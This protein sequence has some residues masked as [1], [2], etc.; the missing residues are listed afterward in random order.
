MASGKVEL[1]WTNKDLRLLSHGV[2][3]YEWVNLNDWRVTEVR[4]LRLVETVGDKGSGNLLIEGDA[5]HTLDAILKIPELAKKYKGKVKLCYIDPPFNTGQAFENYNDAVENSVWLT[6]L[7][8]RLSQIKDLLAPDGSVWL[9]LDDAQAHRARSVLDE[10]FG[11]DNFVATIAWQKADSPRMDAKQFSFSQDYIH[12]YSKNPGWAPNRA[13]Q[14]LAPESEFPY[15]EVDGRRYK[16]SPLRK[17]GKNSARADRPNLWYPITDPDGNE[18]WP[19]KPDG[20][21]GNWRWKKS[22]VEADAHLLHWID[23]GSG[24]QPYTKEYFGQ[25]KRDVPPV[26]WWDNEFADHNR[27]AKAHGK[28]L[29]GKQGAFE[30]PKPERLIQHILRIGSNPGDLVLDCYAGSGTTAAVAHKM[31]RKWITSELLSE[32][33]NKYVMPRLTLVV[34]GEDLGGITIETESVSSSD[35]PEGLTSDE[36]KTASKTLR[37]LS[38]A[39][40]IESTIFDDEESFENLLKE[41]NALAKKTKLEKKIW[42]GGGGF[43]YLRVDPSM[44]VE[45]DGILG[46]AEWATGGALAI[47]IAAQLGYEYKPLGSFIGTKGRTRLA[48]LDGMLTVGIVDFLVAQLNDDETVLIVAQ[49]LEPGIDSY[50]RNSRPGSRCKKI[51]RDLA[52]AS[53]FSKKV[54]KIK[55]KGSDV[56]VLQT[57]D[58]ELG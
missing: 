40:L 58:P 48:V 38:S 7:R 42:E 26:T 54:V 32:T 56:L 25:A 6:M 31:G 28:Q 49:T 55:A 44:F 22:K 5:A 33:I 36:V 52:K 16:S 1:T 24:M 14:K 18:C 29:F 20:T 35:L 46:M 21:E 51:P 3:T 39:G 17:W 50:L 8:D 11:P 4:T 9:H 15:V 23:K 34:N 2:D 12:V 30:T 37:E 43:D 10:V 19:I 45:E 13:P 47:G 41:L 53:P 27:A 57:D